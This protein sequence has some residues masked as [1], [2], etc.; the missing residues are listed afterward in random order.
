MKILNT[1]TSN[2]RHFNWH[3]MEFAEKVHEDGEFRIFKHPMGHP[4]FIHCIGDITIA[5]RVG[6][7][8]TL[9]AD[10]EANKDNFRTQRAKETLIKGQILLENSEEHFDILNRSLGIFPI[11]RK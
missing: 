8:K 7:C 6:A 1:F 10:M 9:V 4:S 3:D 2:S 5:E 11:T